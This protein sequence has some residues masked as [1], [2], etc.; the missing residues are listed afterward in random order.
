MLSLSLG[1]IRAVNPILVRN[2][3]TVR[4]ESSAR[5]L[6]DRPLQR[7][8]FPFRTPLATSSPPSLPD[9]PLPDLSSVCLHDLLLLCQVPGESPNPLA[10]WDLLSVKRKRK[11][12]MAKHKFVSLSL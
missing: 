3:A 9:T 4:W 11:L 6:A 10:S 2:S 5:A 1:Y 8:D 12:K 7:C